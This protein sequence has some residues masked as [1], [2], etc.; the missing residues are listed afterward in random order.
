MSLAI[1][2][3]HDMMINQSFQN[4]QSIDKLTHDNLAFA[5]SGL[6]LKLVEYD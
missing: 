6:F 3:M 2:I 4:L 5:I 1:N